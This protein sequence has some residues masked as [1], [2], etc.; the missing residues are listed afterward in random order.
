MPNSR[1]PTRVVKILD[2][3]ILE[4]HAGEEFGL[5]T[6]LSYCW[7]GVQ[8]F[9]TTLATIGRNSMGCK[10]SDL[11]QTLQD[12]ILLTRMLGLQYIWIDSS[13]IIQDSVADKLQEIPNMSLYYK[14]AYV[15][16]CAGGESCNQGFLQIHDECEQH[17]GL[18]VTK[19]LLK[20]SYLCPDE[21]VGTVYFYEESPYFLSW[22]PISRRAW[23]FQER[24]LSPRVLIY[25]SRLLWQCHSAQHSDGG[26]EDWSFD[27][28]ASDYRRLQINF[29]KVDESSKKQPPKTD[30]S[31]VQY[32]DSSND[33]FGSWYRAVH[34]FSRRQLT[35]PEDKLSAIAGFATEFSKLSGDE[36]LAGLWRS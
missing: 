12:A 10:R 8:R 14:N 35:F 26:V 21:T 17:P 18:G 33:P 27:T 4:L 24:L 32:I 31:S 16:I 6:A 30:I 19:H 23:T 29:T 3:E 13:C 36:Y 28:S 34:E 5:Y 11:P 9:A 7:E 22:E 20:L 15:T 25:G 2:D 1:L